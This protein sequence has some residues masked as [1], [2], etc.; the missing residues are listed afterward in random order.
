MKKL[1]VIVVVLVMLVVA[2][3]AMVNIAYNNTTQA[4]QAQTIVAEMDNRGLVDLRSYMVDTLHGE[5]PQ[6]TEYAKGII[7]Q[8][9]PLSLN[10]KIVC[11]S[12][13]DTDKNRLLDSFALSFSQKQVAKVSFKFKGEE[14]ACRMYLSRISAGNETALPNQVVS[15]YATSQVYL[16]S[17]LANLTHCGLLKLFSISQLDS[18]QL[19]T[20]ITP[21]KTCDVNHI[22]VAKSIKRH[23]LNQA[24]DYE[25]FTNADTIPLSTV[26]NTINGLKQAVISL[27]DKFNDSL[28]FDLSV[29]GLTDGAVLRYTKGDSNNDWPMAS[30][31]KLFIARAIVENTVENDVYTAN[32][33]NYM[34]DML[35]HSN[36]E[37]AQKLFQ[38][39]RQTATDLI[40]DYQVTTY[41]NIP[42]VVLTTE[43]QGIDTD[44]LQQFLTDF[45]DILLQQDKYLPNS[46]GKGCTASAIHLPKGYQVIF[47]KTGTAFV[48]P[49]VKAKLLTIAYK[50]KQGVPYLMLIRIHANAQ[51]AICQG[52]GC[53]GNANLQNIVSILAKA[54]FD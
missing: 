27:E 4:L 42:R 49:Y 38:F 12:L 22:G 14:Q 2:I 15:A 31:A 16:D 28:I 46:L 33:D 10:E 6:A 45:A 25:D 13:T 44:S 18:Q 20:Q 8:H 37:S 54:T 35:C 53:F 32:V 29:T 51:N 36:K 21:S 52:D 47:A 43:N 17:P 26:V 24:Q 50:D 3:F 41:G 39:S 40:K 1:I 34:Q 11:E 30:V 19:L 9:M 23:P 7:N 5:K 48:K